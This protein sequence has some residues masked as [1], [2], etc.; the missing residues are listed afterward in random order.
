MEIVNTED[1]VGFLKLHPPFD[2]LE[3]AD[4]ASVVAASTEVRFE[5]DQDALVE[6]GAPAAHLYVVVDGSMTLVHDGEVVDAVEAGG[7][8]GVPSL[9]TGLAPAFTVRARRPTTCYAVPRS[10]A[11]DV[12]GTVAGANYVATTMRERLVR[13]G[14]V[15]HA[16]PELGTTPVGRLITAE[17][18]FCTGDVTI[19]RAAATMTERDASA[20]LVLDGDRI[21]ILTDALL[22]ARVV[23]GELSP[24][25][26]V[27]RIVEP[28]LVV[29]P[30]RLAVDAIVDMLDAGTDHVVVVDRTRRVVGVLSASDLAGLETRSPFALRHA[31]LRARNEEELVVV[32]GRLRELFLALLEANVSPIDIARVLSLQADSIVSRLIDLAVERHGAAPAPW[33]WLALGS[34]ARRE[35]TLGSDQENALAY[36][37]GGNG[38]VDE[39]FAAVAVEVNRG[40]TRCGFP[41]DPNGVVA[42]S[43]VWRMSEDAWQQTFRDCLDSPD[44]SHLVRANVAFD[45]R[46]ISGSLDVTRPLVA[47]LRDAQTHPD[48]LRRLARSATDFKPP[49]GFRGALAPER[50]EGGGHG[51]D[52]KRGGLVPIVNLARFFALSNGITISG[53]LD[54]LAAVEEAGALE[55]ESATA[56]REAFAAVLQIRLAHHA[57]CL[58]DGQTP[59]NVVDPGT[60][61][62]L[63]RSQLRDAFRAVAAAQK[64]LSVYVPLGM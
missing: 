38:D 30:E 1:V 55:E 44:R 58:H 26:P 9:L 42:E 29:E 57:R 48:F 2:A 5:P 43:S 20:V 4:L 8:F 17:P 13:T 10:T 59:D 64:R 47:V 24:E 18:V 11:L 31:L 39:Y 21:S 40:L 3:D 35:L 45:F 34:E 32:A 62:P 23:A 16:L 22:R 28:A 7:C 46:R 6:D 36:A 54:R 33:A 52:L 19:R 12:L 56:L 49:L 14:H 27:S 37:G 51:I 61:S 15:V 50:Q 53:T 25:N 41:P 63:T 60:L